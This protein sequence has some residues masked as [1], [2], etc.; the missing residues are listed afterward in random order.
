MS[1]PFEYNNKKLRNT[2]ASMRYNGS[3]FSAWQSMAYK[4]L[5]ELLGLES[6][7]KCELQFTVEYEKDTPLWHETRF[8][9][10]SEDGWY[11][12]GH[13]LTP[14]SALG[15]LP[16]MICLQGHSTGMHNSLGVAKFPGDEETQN[17]GDRKF[18][19]IAAER[20][21]C[22]VCI[23]QRC[24]GECGGKPDPKRDGLTE[25]DCYSSSM[26]AI[27]AG[28]TTV[29]E[30]VWD[31]CRLIDVIEQH[32]P[33]ADMDRIYCMGNSGGGTTTFYAACIDKRI[34]ACM[35]SCALCTYAD[36]IGGTYHCACNYIPN[37]AKYFD[38]GDL[39]GLIAPRKFVMVS[40]RYDRIF[41]IDGA[42]ATFELIQ[43]MYTA[44]GVQDNCAWVIGNEG[45]R[46]YAADAYPVFEKLT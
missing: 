18:A 44:A 8:R 39:A 37:I 15:K 5:V 23:E 36:S 27:L 19:V 22:A 43:K 40:G 33:V 3:D 28:R 12:P 32:F 20:G 9:F 34:A 24:F 4:K 35:P 31:V 14:Q 11:V 1:T 17:G 42:K 38:M 29:G 30:R 45:H 25:T 6:F 41:P 16:V 26:T 2:V 7:E 13:F 21:M 10:Q 46:F